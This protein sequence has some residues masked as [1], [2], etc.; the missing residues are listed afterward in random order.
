ML[1]QSTTDDEILCF[2]HSGLSKL[3]LEDYWV[4]IDHSYAEIPREE[5]SSE[6]LYTLHHIDISDTLL[7][8]GIVLSLKNHLQASHY[9][10]H[11]RGRH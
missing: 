7:S 10:Q 9:I 6:E 8:I 5:K 4:Q 3:I 1:T 11:K 2:V